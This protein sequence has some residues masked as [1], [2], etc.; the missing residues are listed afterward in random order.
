[1]TR[2]DLYKELYKETRASTIQ[3]LSFLSIEDTLTIL[4][5]YNLSLED[6]NDIILN[7]TSKRVY[8]DFDRLKLY[9][10]IDLNEYVSSKRDLV[11]KNLPAYISILAQDIP[12]V[13]SEETKWN[14]KQGRIEL[15]KEYI[16]TIV[17]NKLSVFP[18]ILS[19]LYWVGICS[20][21]EYKEDA[22]AHTVGNIGS[23]I[24]TVPSVTDPLVVCL[25]STLR[26]EAKLNQ[27]KIKALLTG[28]T[29]VFSMKQLID[30]LTN[31]NSDCEGG[32]EDEIK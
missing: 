19:Y 25:F 5:K 18:Y 9:A 29:D 10:P 23:K 11:L 22:L 31:L 13:F 24:V 7:K 3:D 2:T 1:M 20:L 14:A 28:D 21:L 26:K 12:I 27:I 6:I 8:F 4:A 15:S 32:A 30:L 17:N 16:N